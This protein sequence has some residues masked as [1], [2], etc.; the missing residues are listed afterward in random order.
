MR[1]Q[2]TFRWHG[3]LLGLVAV[4]HTTADT[5]DTKL[6]CATCPTSRLH[7]MARGDALL[8]DSEKAHNVSTLTRGVRHSLVLELWS[9]PQNMHDRDS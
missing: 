2:V 9:G 1:A 7:E 4:Y 5:I 8:F 3:L 6:A